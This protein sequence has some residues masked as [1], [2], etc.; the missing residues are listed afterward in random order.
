MG[1]FFGQFCSRP[2]TDLKAMEVKLAAVYRDGNEK[3][4]LYADK[5]S[6]IG[7]NGV[8]KWPEDGFEYRVRVL[9]EL[10][11]EK[12]LFIKCIYLIIINCI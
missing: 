4:L 2:E 3:P 7:H 10:P 1:H 11:N 5:K 8:Y 12:V 6:H 9:Q